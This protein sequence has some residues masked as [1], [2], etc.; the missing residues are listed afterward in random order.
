MWPSL[1]SEAGLTSIIYSSEKKTHEVQNVAMD[2]IK[3][4][5]INPTAYIFLSIK[6]NQ[7]PQGSTYAL[8]ARLDIGNWFKPFSSLSG[9]PNR[10]PRSISSTR[11]LVVV[12]L[13]LV[14]DKFFPFGNLRENILRPPRVVFQE[15]KH[16]LLGCSWGQQRLKLVA[17]GASYPRMSLT[18]GS[19]FQ[20][21]Q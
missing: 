13:C 10:S 11:L 15:G 20:N 21:R 17:K 4:A 16:L 2:H 1:S 3:S 9:C 5:D 6:K 12:Q 7:T 8:F 18:V 19:P 14:S